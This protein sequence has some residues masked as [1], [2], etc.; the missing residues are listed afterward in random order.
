MNPKGRQ[1]LRQWKDARWKDEP[2]ISDLVD[3]VEAEEDR[4]KERADDD[5]L[6]AHDLYDEDSAP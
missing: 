2:E 3:E 4:E 5:G 1:T 6:P